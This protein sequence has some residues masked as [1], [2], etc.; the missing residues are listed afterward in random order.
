[1]NDCDRFKNGRDFPQAPQAR[2]RQDHC[3]SGLQPR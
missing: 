2:L 3:A 1:L